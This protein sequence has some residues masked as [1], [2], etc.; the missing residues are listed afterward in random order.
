MSPKPVGPCSGTQIKGTVQRVT[1]VLT[2]ESRNCSL[3]N[4]SPPSDE[5]SQAINNLL[6]STVSQ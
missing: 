1:Q 6:S 4:C 2:I 5:H 3:A